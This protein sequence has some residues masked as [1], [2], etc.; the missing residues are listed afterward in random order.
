[1]Y[2]VEGIKLAVQI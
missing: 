1:M 2:E